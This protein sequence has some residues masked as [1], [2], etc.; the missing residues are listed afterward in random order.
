MIFYS[1]AS[2]LINEKAD[3]H[4]EGLYVVNIQLL[5]MLLTNSRMKGINTLY[6]AV[7]TTARG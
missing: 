3:K 1:I 7:P 5:T 6:Q 2:F 4:D